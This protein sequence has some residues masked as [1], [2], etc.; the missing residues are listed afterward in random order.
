M[1]I[2]VQTLRPH[3]LYNAGDRITEAMTYS[4]P[5]GHDIHCVARWQLDAPERDFFNV[6]QELVIQGARVQVNFLE[7]LLRD[8]RLG[9]RGIIW[10][11]ANWEAPQDEQEAEMTPIAKT[12]KEAVAKGGR[13]WK[14]YLLSVAQAHID[15][16][17]Q[18]RAKGGVPLEAQGFTK[19]ALKEIGWVDPATAVLLAAQA[20][21]AESQTVEDLKKQVE[22]LTALVKGGGATNKPAKEHAAK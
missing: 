11:D 9:R 14:G 19:R 2:S 22:E 18:I 7:T 8:D 15:S 16:C 4:L 1:T 21:K 17:N 12:D 20:N 6:P 10:V 13:R 3:R 5:D